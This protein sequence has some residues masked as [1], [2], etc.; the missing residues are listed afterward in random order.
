MYTQCPKAEQKA[1][2]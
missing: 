1:Q 2:T